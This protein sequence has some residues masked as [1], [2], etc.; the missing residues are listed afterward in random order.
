[1]LKK[2]FGSKLFRLLLSVILIYFAFKK[3][4]VVKLFGELRDVSWWFVIVNIIISF[5][6]VFLVS[7]RWSIL[8]FPKLKIRTI[9]TFTRANFLAYFCSLF[10]PTAIAGDISKWIVIDHKYPEIPKTKVLGSVVLDRFIGF[11]I[12]VLLGLIS[13]IIGKNNNLIIPDYIFYLLI[14]L[15]LICFSIYVMIYFFDVAK[16]LPK[17]TFLH[18]LDDA[19]DLFKNKNRNQIIKCLLIS[20]LTEISWILQTWFVGWKFGTNLGLLEFF[21]FIPIISMI[22]VLPISIAGF[23]A[24][25]QLYL[26]FFSQVN[27]SNESILLMSAFIG[28]LGVINSLF[29][30]FLS[31]FDEKTLK[32]IKS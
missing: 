22:L 9:L 11:S 20:V 23:G 15:N 26:F 7:I 19:F 13:I 14:V 30:G 12:L 21:I 4:N 28:I 2:I 31:L 1:M 18:R 17:I 27:S 3:V 32:K 5:F 29:G 25:E 16:L 10:F 6:I 24:R 8:L